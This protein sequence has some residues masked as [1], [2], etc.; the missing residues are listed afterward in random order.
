M[1][2]A[3]PWRPHVEGSASSLLVRYEPCTTLLPGQQASRQGT[4]GSYE[5]W[6]AD[7]RVETHHVALLLTVFSDD[8]DRH[9]AIRRTGRSQPHIA[10]PRDLRAITPRPIA[11]LLQVTPRDLA[12]VWQREDIGTFPFDQESALV[13]AGQ[14]AHEFRIPKPAIGH[15]YG[16]RQV[17]TTA[18]KG[19]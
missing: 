15:D 4:S 13:G 7:G 1:P 16:R 14:M 6:P 3:R 10:H 9:R 17:H 19:C 11:G 5:L 12:P 2:E 18:A 8:D